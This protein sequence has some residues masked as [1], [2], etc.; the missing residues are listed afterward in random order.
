MGQLVVKHWAR[1]D[2]QNTTLTKISRNSKLKP[3]VWR[4]NDTASGEVRIVKDCAN[5][6][7]FTRGLAR[8]LMWREFRLMERLNGL[9]GVPQ[10]TDRIDSNAFGMSFLA[11]EVLSE[12]NFRL[13]PRR[14][15]DALIELTSKLHQRGV[16]HLDLRQRQNIILGEGLSVQVID[17]GASWAP[18]RLA[19]TFFR[20]MLRDVDKSAALKYLARFA[21]QKLTVD[22]A[23]FLLQK[24]KWRRIW[25]FSPYHSH[26]IEK[27]LKS[28]VSSDPQF[29]KSDHNM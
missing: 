15:A 1:A 28:I 20:S 25:F 29:E 18:N 2:Y 12:D 11:G 26:G 10:L 4:S 21:P 3:E 8:M 14:I 24:L 23:K 13:A 6:P 7:W 5:L 27:A 17:F 16:Y 19:A 22:E 9:D